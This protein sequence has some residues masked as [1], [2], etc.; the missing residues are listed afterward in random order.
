[1]PRLGG[2]FNDEVLEALSSHGRL[3]QHDPGF[4]PREGQRQMAAAVAHALEQK[5]VLVVEAGTGIGKTFAYLIPAL[6]SG[7]R[8]LISTAT[9][10]LQD[11]LFFRDLPRLQKALNLPVHAALLKGRASYLC[12]HRLD[13]AR[14]GDG[15]NDRWMLR[16]LARIETWAQA[17][18]TGDLAEV[19][20]LDERSALIPLVSSTRD[21][22]LGS[23]CPRFSECHVFRARKEAMAADVV[24]VNHHLFFADVALRDSGV[25]ELLPSVEAI[26][27]DEAHQL[28]DTGLQFLGTVLGSGPLVEL[29]KDILRAGLG[30]ARGLGDWLDLSRNLEDAARQLR[31]ACSEADAGA[32]SAT[33]LR[34]QACLE[35]KGFSLALETV[36]RATQAAMQA[37]QAV[38]GSDPELAQL[39]ARSAQLA[40]MGRSFFEPAPE[41]R[42]RWVD[43]S[44]QSV[45]LVES[46]LDIRQVMTE[47]RRLGGKAWIFTS[48]TL[49]EDAQLGWFCAATALE[50]AVKLKIASPFNF[51]T[52]ARLWVPTHLPKPNE[53]RHPAA[54][55]EL[56]ARLAG[57]LGGRTFV[58]TTTL[59]AIE[60]VAQSLQDEAARKGLQLQVLT[61][62]SQPKRMLLSDYGDGVGKVLVGSHSFWEG[63]DVPG[64]ALQCVIIDK[65]PF[66]PPNDPLME[67][68][69]QWIESQ[70]GD[71]FNEL[72]VAEATISLKQGAGRLIRSETDQGLLVICDPRMARM[73]YGRRMRNALPPMQWAQSDQEVQAWLKDLA[74]G[75]VSS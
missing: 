75:H 12:V 59:R 15:L 32:G 30:K 24:V 22:C 57:V 11:Q 71:A 2:D 53:A 37:L 36:S 17:T 63:I 28:G 49:G 68:R 3:A 48:A 66:P 10:G 73:G 14:Q 58:L 38:S 7:C 64:Q 5:E 43:L 34:W 54:V 47:Q 41:G 65:L 27:F 18:R 56:A 9:K 25:A 26:I 44:T 69:S 13:Q 42:I 4:V 60:R 19:D 51:G 20:G 45:R 16:S 1:M 29:G 31:L 46:P 67:A 39:M 62:G 40:A 6:L 21:N 33:R 52:Q 72:F 8:V 35:A 61:Q 23:E 50:D 70:G 55:G 74:R